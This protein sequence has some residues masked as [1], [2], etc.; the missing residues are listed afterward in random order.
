MGS[1][2]VFPDGIRLAHASE[3]PGPES[4][5]VAALERIQ[6]AN[7]AAGYQITE[8]VDARFSHYAEANVDAPR[9]W[10]VF[11]D[12][13]EALLGHSATLLLGHV[14][15]DPTPVGTVDTAELL[16]LLEPHQYQ[17]MHDGW[18]QFGLLDQ[19]HG[20]LNEVFIAPT[21]HFKVWLCDAGRFRAVME[22]HAVPSAGVLE[23]IDQYPRVTTPLGDRAAFPDHDRLVEHFRKE[24]GGLS[25]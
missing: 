3:L 5:R 22:A 9:A 13:C 12:L 20:Q 24:T 1:T 21:K 25:Q 11:R 2:L 17:L 15:D 10:A 16:A 7:I 18:T 23:F 14:D 4:E 19:R 8:A 6:S